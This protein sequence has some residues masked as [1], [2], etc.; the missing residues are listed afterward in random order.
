MH[1]RDDFS[2]VINE[3]RLTGSTQPKE[4]LEKSKGGNKNKGNIAFESGKYGF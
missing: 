4:I 3:I 2:H 1:L